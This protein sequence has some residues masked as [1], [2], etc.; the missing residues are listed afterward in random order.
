MNPRVKNLAWKGWEY[1]LA[2]LGKPAQLP[3]TL[4]NLSRGT[5]P[6]EY[7][8]LNRKWITQSGIRTVIDVGAHA[9]EFSSA[10]HA[11]LPAAMI[12]AFEP[13]AD[14][15]TAL[16]EKGIGNGNLRIFQVAISDQP[17]Q[18]TLWRSVSSKSS[19]L[20][21]MSDVHKANFPW[22]A[23]STPVCVETRTLDSFLSELTLRPKVL[24]KLDV[25]GYEAYVLRGATELLK[26][27][28]YVVLEIAFQTLYQGQAE[29]SDL[30][31]TL[32][33]AGFVF[34]GHLDQVLS[35]LDESITI[36]DALFIRK[37]H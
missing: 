29:F 4:F 20:L 12:Y 18:L 33:R 6:R 3:Q 10:V 1:A 14:C 37:D 22:T 7:L 32:S 35:P 36:A 23:Q 17:G 25:E 15:C 31:D 8:K 9:G 27:V 30:H 16:K 2:I 26:S 34:A 28:D 5:H 19:S 24:L 13:L 21:P 11:V